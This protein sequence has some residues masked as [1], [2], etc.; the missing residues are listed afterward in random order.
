[1]GDWVI[2]RWARRQLKGSSKPVA[3][4]LN[5]IMLAA[6][7]LW[8]APALRTCNHTN[9]VPQRRFKLWYDGFAELFW[10]GASKTWTS[11]K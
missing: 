8:A 6:G 4:G 1:M 5:I 11:K 7:R 2:G 3:A 9:T 10:E